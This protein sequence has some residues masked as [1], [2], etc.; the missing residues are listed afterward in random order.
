MTRRSSSAKITDSSTDAGWG[1]VPP[2]H[3]D[4]ENRHWSAFYATPWGYIEMEARRWTN[5][6]ATWLC[7]I[8][9]GVYYMRHFDR[10]Y[11]RRYVIRLATEFARE[12]AEGKGVE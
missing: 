2:V 12:V 9:R 6:A 11:S 5:S 4:D 10:F 3:D 8:W 7:F 1:I